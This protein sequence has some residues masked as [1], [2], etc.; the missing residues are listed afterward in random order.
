MK[1]TV[2]IVLSLALALLLGVLFINCG[3]SDNNEGTCPEK[4]G[5]G[6]ECCEACPC[7][8]GTCN[9]DGVCE[10]ANE[11]CPDAP[12]G[13]IQIDIDG[14]IK[15]ASTGAGAAVHVAAISPMEALTNPNPTLLVETTSDAS[16]VFHLDCYDVSNVAL[17]AV[18]LT[19]DEP[20]DGAEGSY[21]PTGT[22]VKG[23]TTND[24]KV[25]VDNAVAFAV[26]NTIISALDQAQLTDSAHDGLVMGL[27][28]D[29]SGTPVEGA[30]IKK[31]DG[32]NW[33]DLGAVYYPSADFSDMT[34]TATAST[35]VFVIPGAE[36]AGLTVIHAEKTGM[37]F[38]DAQVAGKAGFCFFAMVPETSE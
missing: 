6:L 26:P 9:A 36:V 22:G 25:C 18:V 12:A 4:C 14:M 7:A 10:A 21:F 37:T 11:C 16:G 34:G 23:W 2:T 29:A 24:E 35:G 27:V 17:G 33:V 38:D 30:V 20:M 19:D 5:A 28:V 15:D 1:K 32:S 31:Q 8:Q 13:Q 3:S